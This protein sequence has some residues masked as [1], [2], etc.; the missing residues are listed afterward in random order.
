MQPDPRIYL[1]AVRRA[2]LSLLENGNV[3]DPVA[4]FTLQRI[5]ESL[6]QM[7]LRFDTL[8]ALVRGVEEEQHALVKDIE[9]IA[10]SSTMVSGDAD[11]SAVTEPDIQRYDQL[12][13]ALTNGLQAIAT[14]ADAEKRQALFARAR[15]LEGSVRS[16]S[17][18][19]AAD[20]RARE[21]RHLATAQKTPPLPTT[22]E[23]ENYLRGLDDSSSVEVSNV[24]RLVGINTKD[25]IFFDVAGQP[26]W[27]SSVVMRKLRNY[28]ANPLLSLEYEFSLLNTL[29]SEGIPVPRAL[30]V[31]P[32]GKALGSPFVI[33]E[34]LAGKAVLPGTNRDEIIGDGRRIGAQI[35]KHL[36]AVHSI[37]I[38]KV[39]RPDQAGADPSQ[40]LRKHIERYYNQWK[41]NRVDPNL[42]IETG[43]LWVLENIQH[44]EDIT[45]LIHGDLDFRNIL[46]DQGNVSALLDWER[47]HL[48]HPAEDLSYCRGDIE[49][50]ME[51][52]EFLDIYRSHGGA[53]ISDRS[54]R[55]FHIWGYLF[56]A[57]CASALSIK[58][59][60]TGEHQDY[61]LASTSYME[62]VEW[63]DTLRTLLDL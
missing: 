6:V 33:M 53:I 55:L 10:R 42:T 32:T 47:S 22:E 23:L 30:A 16:A 24:S 34:K 9:A 1:I 3:T 49:Q 38:R 28:N 13:E 62:G 60:I 61:L 14:S 19:A 20:V 27:P 12:S 25:I 45:C 29:R 41:E 50:L 15:A 37:D 2:L 43:F 17:K 59:Y 35:A 57:M 26:G 51:W 11:D 48:G 63:T 54:L 18:Q 5:A 46:F 58:G 4:T 31:E 40:A 39:A 56:K 8:P 36:A 21:E 44:L 7:S 52:E